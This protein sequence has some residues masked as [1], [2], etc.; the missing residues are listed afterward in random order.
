[1]D[2]NADIETGKSGHCLGKWRFHVTLQDSP[3]LC[4]LRGIYPVPLY[5]GWPR[6]WMHKTRV[7]R[8]TVWVQT[9]AGKC[10]SAAAG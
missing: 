5:P 7:C 1:M 4:E 10:L 9:E 6:G 3:R 8:P 2:A